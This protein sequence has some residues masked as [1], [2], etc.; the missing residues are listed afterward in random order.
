MVRRALRIRQRMRQHTSDVVE[1]REDVVRRALRS[2]RQRMRQHTSAHASAYVSIRKMWYAKMWYGVLCAYVS[3]CV[4]IRQHTPAYVS[5]RQHTSDV[6]V[7]R[8]DPAQSRQADE[9]QS[10]FFLEALFDFFFRRHLRNSTALRR[11]AVDQMKRMA[12][13]RSWHLR[14]S[15]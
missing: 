6:V 7:V 14:G 9:T 5:I 15:I 1:E 13:P 4:S 10:F 12:G 2:I 11:K 3:A 8:E